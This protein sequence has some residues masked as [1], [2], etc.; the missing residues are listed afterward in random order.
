MNNNVTCTLALRTEKKAGY[1]FTKFIQRVDMSQEFSSRLRIVVSGEIFETSYCHVS[2]FPETLLGNPLRRSKYLD[3]IKDIYFFDRHRLAFE[4]ILFYYQSNGKILCPDNVPFEVFEEELK[5]FGIKE[6]SIPEK[7]REFILEP[8][9]D[10]RNQTHDFKSKVWIALQDPNSSTHA[11]AISVWSFTLTLVS[12]ILAIL[13]KSN[14]DTVNSPLFPYELLCFMWFTVECALRFWSSPDKRHF[15]RNAVDIIDVFSIVIYYAALI[16]AT[17]SARSMALLRVF[18][19]ANV[20]RILKLTRY[21]YGLRLL[22]YTVYT[23]R[24]DLQILGACLLFFILITSSLMF[25]VETSEPKSKIDS[26]LNAVWW[27]IVTCT[28]VGYGDTVPMT[29]L[30]KLV[31]ACTAI[32]GA[33]MVLLPVLKLVQSFGDAL[34][35]AKPYLRNAERERQS[36][37]SAVELKY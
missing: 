23:S 18:R 36:K 26:I 24:L 25:Y 10:T 15:F 33:L 37:A 6:Q 21:F 3:P 9:K 27:A 31:G 13:T 1:I 22:L 20:F 34:L 4:G 7:A 35:A 19:I 29:T 11:K 32:F 5:F 14:D 17:F 2:K 8:F 12:I 30:G 16:V 28:T